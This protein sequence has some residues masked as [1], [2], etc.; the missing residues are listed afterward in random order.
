MKTRSY[1]HGELVIYDGTSP[2]PY[3]PGQTARM[4]LRL[5]LAPLS[6]ERLDAV[7]ASGD[8]RSGA[9]LYKTQCPSC[10]AC[11]PLRIEVDRFEPNRTQR[12][13]LRRGDAALVTRI[14]PPSVDDER[15]RLYNL[16]KQSRGLDRF[17]VE[18]EADGYQEFLVNSCC[19]TL[20]F[21][22]YLDERLVALAVADRGRTSLSAVYCY[23][24]PTHS[25]LGLGTYSILKQVEACREWGLTHLY[26]G[27]YVEQATHLAYK[28]NF[29]PHE[30]LIDGRWVP[31]GRPS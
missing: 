4:P 23:F 15:V 1:S 10:R 19:D 25:D 26:L 14:G 9:V 30:R 6:P 17:G 3:L 8:R 5:P 12:K 2:C 28:A 13:T 7:L 18:T 31:F 11:E 29:L 20:E 21:R 24:D 27:L 22:Y 16:H